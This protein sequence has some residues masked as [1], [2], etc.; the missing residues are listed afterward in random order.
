MIDTTRPK[1]HIVWQGDSKIEKAPEPALLITALKDGLI[2]IQQENRYV[3]INYEN[4]DEICKLLK[5][6]KNQVLSRPRMAS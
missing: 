1:S 2:E 5:K 3:I 4:I 6:L